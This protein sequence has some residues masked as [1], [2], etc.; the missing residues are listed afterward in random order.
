MTSKNNRRGSN[1]RGFGSPKNYRIPK[2]WDTLDDESKARVDKLVARFRRIKPDVEGEDAIMDRQIASYTDD[3]PAV[4]GVDF[5]VDRNKPRAKDRK[6]ALFGLW[7]MG[8]LMN[9]KNVQPEG[10]HLGV[11]KFAGKLEPPFRF[12]LDKW[13]DFGDLFNRSS[14][15]IKTEIF[16]KS[17]DKYCPGCHA[18]FKHSLPKSWHGYCRRC[19]DELVGGRD[20]HYSLATR[21]RV[22]FPFDSDFGVSTKGQRK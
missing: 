14:P 20:R 7:A 4:E 1:R 18:Y 17:K 8:D 6:R 19:S 13:H 10:H 2:A 15:E 16:N 21:K 22:S 5:V 12:E 3:E 9:P 11:E